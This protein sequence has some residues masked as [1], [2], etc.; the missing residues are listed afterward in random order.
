MTGW[1]MWEHDVPDSRLTVL[2]QVEDYIEPKSGQHKA[3]WLCE[4]SCIE[5]NKIIAYGYDV[6]HGHT[7]SCGCLQKEIASGIGK[8]S[9][10]IND[11][12]LTGEYGVG[13]TTNT[14]K[15]FYFDLE[16]YDKI[17]DYCWRDSVDQTG[18]HYLATRNGADT[19]LR[20]QHL[21]AGK[22]YDHIDKNPFNNRK[23]NL[24]PA[25]PN[26]NARN[27]SLQRNNTSGVSGVSFDKNCNKWIAYITVNNKHK[28]LGCFAN[29]EDAIKTR[30]EAEAKYFGEFASQKHLF[31][32]YEINI[33]GGN[34]Q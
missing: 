29:K 24:R 25:N 4:C 2:K 1:K 21:I 26:E 6:R 27:K 20:M 34:N 9:K 22:Y 32:Q 19:A 12:D 18:Y 8:Q 23:N 7:K 14:N 28:Y 33:E 13:W 15:E 5:H 17:K 10:K 16:D 3:Q 30:L 11:Y 31:E